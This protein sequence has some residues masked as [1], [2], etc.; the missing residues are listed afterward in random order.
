M[1]A[2]LADQEEMR[3][4]TTLLR[5]VW[6]GGRQMPLSQGERRGVSRGNSSISLSRLLILTDYGH[7]FANAYTYNDFV[8]S[9]DGGNVETF[10]WCLNDSPRGTKFTK[11][12]EFR[13]FDIRPA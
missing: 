2:L 3:P 7:G 4:Q 9:P 6:E 5:K 10:I 11:T 8:A 1:P 13:R 12:Q